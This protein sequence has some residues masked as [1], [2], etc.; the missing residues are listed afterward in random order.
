MTEVSAL[1]Q[2]LEWVMLDDVRHWGIDGRT[3]DLAFTV[4]RCTKLKNV[5]A[6]VLGVRS[7][8]TED[9]R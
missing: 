6:N 1:L 5:A 2:G 7:Q 4:R 3:I 9:R 8:A